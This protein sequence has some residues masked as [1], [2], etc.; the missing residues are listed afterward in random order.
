MK[1]FTSFGA[2]IAAIA[3]ATPA[4]TVHQTE[5]PPLSGPSSLAQSLAVTSSPQ[6][7]TQNAADAALVTAKVYF[8]DPTTGKNA[9]KANLPI[10]YSTRGGRV[11]HDY[12]S[13]S[14]GTAVT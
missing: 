1:A 4:C 3:L 5:A 7:I 9:P 12:G 11:T 6:A 14:A 2:A 10:R 8:N 13:L